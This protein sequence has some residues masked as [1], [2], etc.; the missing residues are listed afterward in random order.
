[1]NSQNVTTQMLLAMGL[2][3]SG[4]EAHSNSR[5]LLNGT[6]VNN[7]ARIQN[8]QRCKY[9]FVTNSASCDRLS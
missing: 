3:V 7:D 2:L 9:H 6:Y 1:M 8:V 4:I 5:Q